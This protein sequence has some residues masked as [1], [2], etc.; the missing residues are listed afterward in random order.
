MPNAALQCFIYCFG[1]LVLASALRSI[2]ESLP[3]SA[4][5]DIL[6]ISDDK[7]P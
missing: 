1:E 6:Y 2:A 7:P 3:T 4:K 5:A